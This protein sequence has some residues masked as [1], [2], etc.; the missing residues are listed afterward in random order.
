MRLAC[1]AEGRIHR[2]V[3][4]EMRSASAWPEDLNRRDFR[5]LIASRE[6]LNTSQ[7]QACMLSAESPTK[8][9]APRC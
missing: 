3:S 1:A 8:P 6:A 9:Q 4:G 2:R 5:E 7:D